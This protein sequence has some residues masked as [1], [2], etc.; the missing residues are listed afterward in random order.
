MLLLCHKHSYLFKSARFWTPWIQIEDTPSLLRSRKIWKLCLTRLPVCLQQERMLNQ[1]GGNSRARDVFG[2]RCLPGKA[3]FTWHAQHACGVLTVTTSGVYGEEMH[4]QETKSDP[5]MQKNLIWP[6]QRGAVETETTRRRETSRDMNS[7]L[8]W[9]CLPFQWRRGY[10]VPFIHN[11]RARG[12]DPLQRNSNIYPLQRF[13][14]PAALY[15][16]AGPLTGPFWLD[17]V[18]F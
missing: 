15:F 2:L 8:W 6:G 14:L 5:W 12:Q 11:V 13:I 4:N 18:L 1:S 3:A 17:Q 16:S 10:D 7:S 9:S